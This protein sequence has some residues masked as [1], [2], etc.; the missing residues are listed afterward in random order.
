MS[1]TAEGWY[2]FLFFVF[3]FSNQNKCLL[4]S[5]DSIQAVGVSASVNGCLSP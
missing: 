2:L 5:C 1:I 4:R 3:A